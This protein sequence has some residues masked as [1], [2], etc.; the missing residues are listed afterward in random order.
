MDTLLTYFRHS[1]SMAGQDILSIGPLISRSMIESAT[2]DSILDALA[3]ILLQYQFAIDRIEF[4]S[5]A[6][7]E[8]EVTR[9][10]IDTSAINSCFNVQLT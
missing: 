3:Y 5:S 2:L 9:P 1:L 7:A 10:V 4:D 8:H 6:N